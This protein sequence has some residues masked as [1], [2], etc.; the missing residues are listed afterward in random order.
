MVDLK[1][2]AEADAAKAYAWLKH[3]WWQFGIGVLT[4]IALGHVFWK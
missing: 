3:F 1:T 4:G 2:Q